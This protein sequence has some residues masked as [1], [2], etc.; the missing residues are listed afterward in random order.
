MRGLVKRQVMA[1]EYRKLARQSAAAASASLLGNVR[2]KHARAALQW[3]S[4]A[5]LNERSR[6]KHEGDAPLAKA[7]LPVP[8][9]AH[10]GESIAGSPCR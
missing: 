10:S 5:A 3:E 8:E 7:E 1:A 9:M 4:L 6:D 2:E